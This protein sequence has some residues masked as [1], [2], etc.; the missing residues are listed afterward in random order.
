MSLTLLGILN[1]QA[2]GGGAGAFDLL[3]TTTLS[4][5][6]SSVTFSGLGAYSDYKHL[7]IRVVARRASSGSGGDS[8]NIR[9]NGDTGSNYAYHRLYGFNGSVASNSG[10]SVS[11]IETYKVLPGNSEAAGIFGSVIIDALDFSNNSKKT[12][13]RTLGGFTASSDSAESAV[14]LTSGLWNNTNA[15]TSIE[16]YYSSDFLAGSRFSL[17]GVK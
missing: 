15:V 4:T 14:A 3:E 16:T 2:A 1:A 17:Y 8:M 6:S 7:Q 10:S 12:T 13:L 11:L 5:A 9:V